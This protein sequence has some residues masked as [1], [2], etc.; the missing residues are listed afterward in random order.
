MQKSQQKGGADM[1]GHGLSDQ[2]SAFLFAGHVGFLSEKTDLERRFSDTP[3]VRLLNRA[4]PPMSAFMS[5]SGGIK[6]LVNVGLFVDADKGGHKPDIEMGQGG[7]GFPPL[8]GSLPCPGRV[9]A[10]E[11][12][13]LG[14]AKM[15]HELPSD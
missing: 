15:G 9:S 5:A 11:N 7:H 2:L 14:R 1:G 4:C 13:I 6:V 8:G 10:V 12:W 3:H